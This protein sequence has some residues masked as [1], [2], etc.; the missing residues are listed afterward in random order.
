[1]NRRATRGEAN[2]ASDEAGPQY[3]WR[4]EALRLFLKIA[5]IFLPA[6]V[7]VG[8]VL[9]GKPIFDRTMLIIW[10]AA[11]AFLVLRL[12]PR[13]PFRVAAWF[14]IAIIYVPSLSVVPSLGVLPGPAVAA[15]CASVLAAIYFGRAAAYALL[16]G[17]IAVFLVSGYL[18]AWRHIGAPRLQDI[19][20]MLFRNWVR[21]T[22][23]FAIIA[24]FLT[25][26]VHFLVTHLERHYESALRAAVQIRGA[27]ARWRLCAE[28][29]MA[30]A[31]GGA[32]ESGDLPA[33]FRSICEAGVRA[34]GVERCS[35]WLLDESGRTLRCHNLFERTPAQHSSGLELSVDDSPTY[36]AALGEERVVAVSAAQRDPRTAELRARYLERHGIESMLDA[37]IHDRERLVGVVCHEQVG[38]P[39]SWPPEA[40]SFAG[41]IA[42]FAARAL[43]AAERATKDQD[44]RVAYQQ[45]GQLNRRLESAKEEERR[46]LAHELHDELGQTLTALKIRFQM[47]AR[48]GG[49]PAESGRHTREAVALVDG[50]IGRVRQISV[51]LRPP[52]LD[53]VGLASALRVYVDSQASHA[54]MPMTLTV[55]GLDG[56]LAPEIEMACYRIVQEAITNVLRHAAATQVEVHVAESGG[57]VEIAVRDDGRGFVPAEVLERVGAGSHL[58]LIGMRERARSFGGELRL[59]SRPG[60]G[61]SVSVRLPLPLA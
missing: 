21:I 48:S 20:P 57:A 4:E 61:T 15:V 43:L 55:S 5:S 9:R 36:F 10:G 58:G 41:S 39:I 28:Q 17:T 50:L 59:S 33:A 51:D 18:I 54:G 2:G 40:Q 26:A 30:L 6:I 53:E 24:T 31:R 38:P 52:L 16:A 25:T 29:L 44:L 11:A 45:V 23:A 35:V 37:P 34:L 46:F 60:G 8:T 19:D 3:P 13:V 56:R 1:M 32:V 47:L 14:S 27:D 7:I 22:S 42:D 49:D 12:S